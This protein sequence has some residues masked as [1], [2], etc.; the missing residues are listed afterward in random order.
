VIKVNVKQRYATDAETGGFFRALCAEAGVPCQE[1]VHRADLPCGSTIGPI[2]AGQLGAR[3]V[4]V[5]NPMLSMHS[6][7][8]LAGAED[9]ALMVAAMRLFFD[10]AGSL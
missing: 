7:R 9:P 3:V 8:E 2:T 6:A 5:G 1:Y 10:G 4:D